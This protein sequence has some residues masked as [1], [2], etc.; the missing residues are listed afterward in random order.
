MHGGGSPDAAKMALMALSNIGNKK[1]MAKKLA[2][3][4]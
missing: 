1:E 3:I 4:E 2:G